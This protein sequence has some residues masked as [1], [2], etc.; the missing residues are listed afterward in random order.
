MRILFFGD[1]VTDALRNR[2]TKTGINPLGSGYA[3]LVAA[4][5]LREDPLGYTV[6]NR[7]ISGNRIVDLYARVK[8]DCW[9]EEPDLISILIGVNEVLHE[10]E[11]QNGVEVPRYAKM[12]D[13]LIEDTKAALPHA[14]IVICEPFS[15]KMDESED[16][17]ARYEAVKEYGAAARA[18]AERHG[19]PFV[20]LQDKMDEAAGIYGPS[21]V[22]RDGVHPVTFGARLIADEWLK[23]FRSL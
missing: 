6:L 15:L 18:A 11:L 3:Y 13:M 21:A 14:R 19:L 20:A 1:S 9:N 12:Y 2:D 23:V 10:R 8:I 16:Q 7:G 4:D 22:L 5:L 17:L